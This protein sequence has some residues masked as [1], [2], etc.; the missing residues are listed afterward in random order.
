[1]TLRELGE[2]VAVDPNGATH[3]IRAWADDD[4]A[5]T[6]ETADGRPVVRVEKG[7]YELAAA[8]LTSD[9]PNAP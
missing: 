2:F 9:D 3:V 5:I 7:R 6:L 4:G 1:M 8:T